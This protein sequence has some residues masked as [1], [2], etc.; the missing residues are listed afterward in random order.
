MWMI[1]HGVTIQM[2]LIRLTKKAYARVVFTDS[3][4]STFY[5]ILNSIKGKYNRLP[6]IR[7]FKKIIK[8][9]INK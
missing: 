6:I 1:S 2:K 9:I 4:K 5:S 3:K 7:T 8:K